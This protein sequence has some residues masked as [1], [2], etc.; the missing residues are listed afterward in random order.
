MRNGRERGQ[1]E[2]KEQGDNN[3]SRR[4]MEREKKY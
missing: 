4:S 3:R 2:L 1:E